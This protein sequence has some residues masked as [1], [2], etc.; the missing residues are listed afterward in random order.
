MRVGCWGFLGSGRLGVNEWE[1]CDDEMMMAFMTTCRIGM[2]TA[3]T[4]AYT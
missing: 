1:G 3:K 2:R 4:G